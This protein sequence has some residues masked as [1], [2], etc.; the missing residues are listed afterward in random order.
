MD[1][2][3]MVQIWEAVRQQAGEI[4]NVFLQEKSFTISRPGGRTL[5]E[6]EDAKRRALLVNPCVPCE[7]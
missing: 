7:L 3:V 4:G 2:L 5:P 6:R 1:A